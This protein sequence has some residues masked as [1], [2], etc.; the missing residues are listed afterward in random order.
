LTIPPPWLLN[1]VSLTMEAIA[2]R[3]VISEHTPNS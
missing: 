2:N 3:T 1:R